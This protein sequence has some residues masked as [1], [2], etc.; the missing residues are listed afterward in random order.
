MK[1]I[2][3]LL[4]V[5][6]ILNESESTPNLCFENNDPSKL[7]MTMTQMNFALKLLRYSTPTDESS[8]LSPSAV[9]SALSIL[10]AGAKGETER[11][12]GVVLCA[13]QPKHVFETYIQ[14]AIENIRNQSECNDY[15]LGYSTKLWTQQNFFL[16]D[17]KDIVYQ[18]NGN[19]LTEIDFASP[20]EKNKIILA[21]APWMLDYSDN[22]IS[23]TVMITSENLLHLFNGLY[24]TDD[25][26]YEFSSLNYMSSFYLAPLQLIDMP[27]METIAEFPYYEDQQVQMVSL[28]LKNS[29]TQMLI[30]LPKQIFGL[31]KLENELTGE[32]L[33]SYFKALD[34]SGKVMVRMPRIR[35]AK[36]H[37][38]SNELKKMGVRSI[39]GGSADFSGISN[40]TLYITED[41]RNVA[42][43]EIN[44]EGINR[45]SSSISTSSAMVNDESL[46]DKQIF[47][48][49]HPFLFV[50]IDNHG[51]ILWIGRYTGKEEKVF[52]RNAAKFIENDQG[53]MTKKNEVLIDETLEVLSDDKFSDDAM[54]ISFFENIVKND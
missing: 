30:I 6:A 5:L 39:F 31:A 7:L 41:I 52:L 29:K 25:W 14:C 35:L 42:L 17:L 50:I 10:Y 49:N 19:E 33:F 34:V 22:G 9:A 47:D 2:E 36:K 43:I 21:L 8:L 38:L 20:L 28:P 37:F 51:I 44:E 48:V 4:V 46:L 53:K 12:I 15:T 54:D 23:N 27:T 32:K 24:F 1:L 11:E 40:Q 45:K 3:I 18:Q 13:G 16:S 26:R